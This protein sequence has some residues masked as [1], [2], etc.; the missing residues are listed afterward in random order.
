MKRLHIHPDAPGWAAFEG[1]LNAAGL[2]TADLADPGQTFFS[3]AAG[4]AFGGFAQAGPACSCAG[5]SSL[6]IIGAAG[7]AGGAHRDPG[8]VPPARLRIRLASDGGRAGLLRAPRLRRGRP[9]DRAACGRRQLA[10]HRPVPGLRGVDV[11]QASQNRRCIRSRPAPPPGRGPGTALLLAVVIGSGIMGERLAG[12][13]VAIALLGNTLAT[14][15]GLV[16]L[17]TIFGP[18]SGAHFNPA[19]TLVFALRREIGWPSGPRL[20]RRPRSPA[21][22]SAS[23]RARHVRRADPA[24]LDQAARRPGPG[25]AEVVA[26]F[27]LIATILGS[28]RFRPDATPMHGRALHHVGL[29]VHGLDLVRQSGRDDGPDAVRTPSPASRPVS[30]PLF[31]VAQLAGAVAG[32]RPVRLAAQGTGPP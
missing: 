28:L 3:F 25:L 8:R 7:S 32:G 6:R 29:L 31:I 18:L 5:W 16:V 30:A 22:I 27:G 23:G 19:V 26:T 14:G 24:G 13:N 21:A 12:G 15:A 9:R 1:A 2:P 20:Y 11:S 17:I 10:I 4:A